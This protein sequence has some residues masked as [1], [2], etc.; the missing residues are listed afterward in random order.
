MQ[1]PWPKSGHLSQQTITCIREKHQTECV[2]S[3]CSSMVWIWV[4]V[5]FTVDTIFREIAPRRSALNEKVPKVFCCRGI[6]WK[7]CCKTNNGNGLRCI[8][9][10]EGIPVLLGL[11]GRQLVSAVVAVVQPLCR[12]ING[13]FLFKK[14]LYCEV[15]RAREI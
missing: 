11:G 13:F 2:K 3:Y 7:A 8:T 14:G 4:V 5:P 6:L 9:K 10:I 1:G 12:H 15:S